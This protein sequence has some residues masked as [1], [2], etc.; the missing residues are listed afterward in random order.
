MDIHVNTLLSCVDES[1]L[2]MEQRAEEQEQVQEYPDHGKK[3]CMCVY[4]D[5]KTTMSRD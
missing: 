1:L 5:A 2:T 3:I 4:Y